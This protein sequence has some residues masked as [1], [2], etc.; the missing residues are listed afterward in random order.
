MM[1]HRGVDG[2]MK[3]AR[4]PAWAAHH[5]MA[6]Q[7]AEGTI[8]LGG[9]TIARGSFLEP[10]ELGGAKGLERTLAAR[11]DLEGRDAWEWNGAMRAARHG[12][13]CIAWAC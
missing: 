7:V 8:E 5:V 6:G 9:A 2:E 1:G 11:A 12:R 4:L 10:A 3:S 13:G